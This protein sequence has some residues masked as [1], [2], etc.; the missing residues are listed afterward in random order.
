MWL[1]KSNAALWRDHLRFDEF[2]NRIEN[3]I[4]C[5]HDVDVDL[6]CAF[7]VKNARQH[8][9]ALFCKLAV[10]RHGVEIPVKQI[11]GLDKF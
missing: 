10:F 6:D 8:G 1:A 2:S 7:A 9:H 4:E 3:D 11:A 5:S